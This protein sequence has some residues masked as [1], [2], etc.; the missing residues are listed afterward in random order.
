MRD[1]ENA[2][3]ERGEIQIGI[4][5]LVKK[6][7]KLL[8]KR[9]ARKVFDLCFGTGRHVIFLAEN[10]FDVYGIDISK[11]GKAITERKIKQKGLKNV[12]LK[13]A[14]MRKIPF[15][16]NTFDA[17]IAVNALQ[18][19]TLNGVKDTIH[20]LKRVLKPN[21]TLVATLIST[22]DPRY[23]AG[24]QVEPN[25]FT[26]LGDDPS[27]IDVPHHFSDKKEA[28]ELFSQF[29]RVKLKEAEGF[30]ERRQMKAVHWEIIAEK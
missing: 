17:V 5:P 25:T 2:Y 4:E 22:K 18:H 16:N 14:D 1:W 28:T 21:G 19:N 10:G 7:L 15:K 30:S 26:D 20:E 12:H 8:K 3:K 6:S 27:D 23:K 9:K 29:N 24:K 11:T 13:V